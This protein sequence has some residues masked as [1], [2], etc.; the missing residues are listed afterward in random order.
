MA[1]AAAY[2]IVCPPGSSNNIHALR[3]QLS[4]G[5]APT[6]AQQAASTLDSRPSTVAASVGAPVSAPV[7][8]GPQMERTVHP[9]PPGTSI[10]RGRTPSPASALAGGGA[11]AAAREKA[12]ERAAAKRQKRAEEAASKLLVDTAVLN[13]GG[14]LNKKGCPCT[15]CNAKREAARAA[16]SAAAQERMQKKRQ[17]DQHHVL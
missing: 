3:F 2:R 12:G 16:D 6:A 4:H 5:V 11:D 10:R 1:E 9:L 15:A 17:Q 7:V 13:A 8:L 14:C